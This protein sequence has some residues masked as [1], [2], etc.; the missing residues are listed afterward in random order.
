[1]LGISQRHGTNVLLFLAV[2]P[3]I[4]TSRRRR[5]IY[6]RR[7]A[8]RKVACFRQSSELF[9]W[10]WKNYWTDF[11]QTYGQILP[12]QALHL[13]IFG[14]KVLSADSKITRLIKK[15]EKNTSKIEQPSV[16]AYAGRAAVIIRH[17]PDQWPDQRFTSINFQK[18][19]QSTV[20]TVRYLSQQTTNRKLGT[21][22]VCKMELG[23]ETNIS[24]AS[25]VPFNKCKIFMD[26]GDSCSLFQ[27]DDVILSVVM[28]TMQRMHTQVCSFT[29]FGDMLGVTNFIR[30]TWLRLGPFSEIL[31]PFWRNCSYASAC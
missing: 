9:W 29:H 30:V 22:Y 8:V 21:D 6:G 2:P 27:D 23:S 25:I 10:S 12:C 26:T 5:M 1:M 15:D 17:L 24:D 31:S 13:A 4:L 11:S 16:P 14:A 19:L 18:Q 28:T 3:T 7:L 20:Q